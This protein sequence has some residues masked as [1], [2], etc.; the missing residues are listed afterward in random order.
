MKISVL[1]N[2]YNYQNY[3]VDAIDSV[4][5]QSVPV[6]EIIVVDDKS[7]DDSVKL[8]KEKYAGHEKVKLVL[9]NENQGQLSSFHEGFFASSG[10]IICFLDADDLYKQDYVEQI[11]KF[12]MQHP[13]CDF[14]FC[15]AEV[16]GN[17]EKIVDAYE[18]NR[19]LGISRIVTLYQKVWLGHRT[20]T[21]SMRRQV[22]DKIFPIPYLEDWRIRAD[23][24]LTYGSSI[25]G[26]RKFYLAQPL[27][28]YRVHGQNGYY[29][30]SHEKTTE[31]K[32]RYEQ[33]VERLIAYLSKKM[34]YPNNLY[35]QAHI[36]FRTIPHPLIQEYVNVKSLLNE[37]KLPLW[38]KFIM[39]VSIY[40]HF[41]TKGDFSGRFF[42]PAR[43]LPASP[44]EIDVKKQE[45]AHS[46]LTRG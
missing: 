30:R 27:I 24:C 21:F 22:L 16:F 35:E 1:I 41:R 10:D 38:K 29:G 8:L 26:A 45:P 4:L 34:N 43:Q 5:L 46:L 11:V 37:V 32:Q 17:E 28:K 25:V 23:D 9:K 6:D 36:E 12:Y 15:S 19:D 2:N 18:T 44:Q 20:S 39:F 42:P 14:L 3:V 33:A 31:Y 40:T 7:T 13:E